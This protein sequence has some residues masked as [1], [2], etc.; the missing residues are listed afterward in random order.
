MTTDIGHLL[1]Q[2]LNPSTQKNAAGKLAALELQPGFG[3]NLLVHVT[4]QD[5]NVKMAAAVYFKNYIKKYWTAD[6]I[7]DKDKTEVKNNILQIMISVDF[8]LQMQISEAVIQIANVDF[9][10]DWEG[11]V[12]DLVSRLQLEDYKINIGVLTTAHAIFKRWR[13]Q[14]RSDKL[15]TEIKQVLLQFQEPFLQFL[16]VNTYCHKTASEASCRSGKRKVFFFFLFFLFSFLFYF[17]F[18]FF[19]FLFFLF[20]LFFFSKK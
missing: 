13:H 8:N 16:Q 4:A 9:P 19:L 11:L 1:L 3:F 2:T 10:H 12:P 18:S 5:A 17:F 14:F 7:S 6:Q 15:F 20:F